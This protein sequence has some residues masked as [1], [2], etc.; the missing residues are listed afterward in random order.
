MMTQCNDF[1]G[2]ICVRYSDERRWLVQCRR[3]LTCRRQ[4]AATTC[5][6][7]VTCPA[8]LSDPPV[9]LPSLFRVTLL[10]TADTSSP[11]FTIF[12]PCTQ[13]VE[14]LRQG[15]CVELWSVFRRFTSCPVS[16]KGNRERSRLPTSR[17]R[18]TPAGF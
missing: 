1:K 2:L 14:G 17:I 16:K 8:S 10:R 9:L 11:A 4:L 3:F 18:A 13:S 15:A 5:L 12:Y 6:T 7:T